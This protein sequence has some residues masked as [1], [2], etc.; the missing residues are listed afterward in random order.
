MP[1]N[2]YEIRNE[3]SLADPE[4][5]RAADKDDPEALLEGVAMAGLVGV[6]RQLG[7]LA[8][9]AAEIFRDL[10]EEVMVTAARGH[11]LMV[12]VEQLE[13]D[14]PLIEKAFLSQTNHSSFF[15]N[16]GVDWH[17]N[18]KMDQNL[19]TQG[20]LP[21]FIMDSYEECRGPP[22][23]FLLDKFDVAGAGAC[24]KRYTDPSSFK[25]EALSSG[26]TSTDVQRVKKTR[27]AKQKKGPHWRNGE[28]REVV[29]PTAHAK[30]HQ[31]FLKE[32]V[33]NGISNPARR[34]KLKRKLNGFPFNLKTGKS[35]MEKLLN[36]SSPEHKVVHEVS[37]RSSPLKLPTNEPIETGPKVLEVRPV[38]T[39]TKSVGRGR[40][41]PSSP[42]REGP[43]LQASV[44][45][46]NE[47]STDDR[48]SEVSIPNPIYEADNSSFASHGVTSG[49]DI[50][51]DEESKTEGSLDG[52]QSDD[53]A[54]ERENYVD[55]P[56]TMDSE[57]DTD[58]ELRGKSDLVSLNI[59]RQ[60]SISDANE[61]QLQAHSSGSQSVATSTLS[62]DGK[63]EMSSFSLSDT[64]ST[65][66]EN[67]PSNSD[68]S[69][70]ILSSTN[71]PETDIL[72]RS[73][74]L[75]TGHGDDS[76][77]QD[78]KPV[79]TDDTCVGRAEIPGHT[80]F[81][82][83]IPSSCVTDAIPTSLDLDSTSVVGKGAFSQSD[84]MP[85]TNIEITGE[86]IHTEHDGTNM[87]TNL[88]YIPSIPSAALLV[89]DDFPPRLSAE[90]HLTDESNG[91]MCE[92]VPGV[93]MV[94]DV[95]FHTGDNSLG[96]SAE[97]LNS[98]DSDKEDLNLHENIDDHLYMMSSKNTISW[99]VATDIPNLH[100]N[101]K[102]D[103]S[104]T[105][106][107][108]N[109]V[110]TPIV[111][112]E[113]HLVDELDDE[114]PNVFSDA[115]NDLS[116]ILEAAPENANDESSLD[117]MAQTVGANDDSTCT[118]VYNPIGSPNLI[119]PHTEENSLY[120]PRKDFGPHDACDFVISA[121]TTGNEIP[122]AE[123]PKSC[124]SLGLQGMGISNDA[125]PLVLANVESSHCSEENLDEPLTTSNG[126]EVDGINLCT[127]LIEKDATD[128]TLSSDP[129]S[130]DEVH[131]QLDEINSEADQSG[132]VV[133][134][135][136]V[137]ATDNNSN[138]DG[139]EVWGIN[140]CIE[141]TGKDASDITL[142]PD[143]TSLNKVH[144]QLDEMDSESYQSG[145]VVLATNVAA[146]DINSDED[147]VSSSVDLNKLPE[148]STCSSGDLDQN[149]FK[150]ETKYLPDS[151]KQSGLA[152]EVDQLEATMSGSDA[153][154]C[155]SPV[156]L[157]HPKSE[158]SVNVPHSYRDLEVENTSDLINAARTQS[159]LEQYGLA[160]E[161]ESR[162]QGV[163]INHVEDSSTSHIHHDA[164]EKIKLLPNQSYQEDFPD[165]GEENLEV[166]QL[167]HVQNLD[168]N[169]PEGSCNASC[170]LVNIQNQPFI[171]EIPVPGSYDVNMSGYSKD[172][173]IS[174]VPPFNL[175]SEANLINLE[176]LPPLPPLPPV[177]WRTGKLQHASA[178]ERIAK[179]HNVG[180]FLSSLPVVAE[181]NAQ[182]QNLPL[183]AAKH[184]DSPSSQEYSTGN[185]M[186]SGT[187]SSQ[188][189]HVDHPSNTENNCLV[190]RG[191]QVMNS[192][193]MLP[194]RY[195]EMPQDSFLMEKGCL[196][197]SRLT[198]F[199]QETSVDTSSTN[200]VNSSNE[201]IRPSYHVAPE[202]SSKEEEAPEISS[203]EEVAP[204]INSKVK[205]APEIITK[206]EKLV[207]S[208]SSVEVHHTRPKAVE[209]LPP[210]MPVLVMP[211]SEGENTSPP[212]EDGIANGS[213]SMKQPRPR[214]PLIDAV[215]ARDKS[216]LR[217]VTERIRPEIQKVDERD[218][219]LEQIRS[220]SFNLKPAVAN[221]PS[222]RGPKTNLKVAA[223]LEK[224][225][226]I[227]QAF[228]GS[229]D[230]DEDR[231][232]DP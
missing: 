48:I 209:F 76:V 21:R 137:A 98:N 110:C 31:L 89:K 86:L 87:V 173:L 177:Q 54:S 161:Q 44:Y 14:V 100:E 64:P 211:S 93:S 228:V 210:K 195:D 99:I 123:N 25:V 232:S 213:R 40:S 125:Y 227:R 6:L 168:H 142:S 107:Q 53:I 90:N 70:E 65:S 220:K 183:S 97:H 117:N 190:L 166:P 191:N 186:Q 4:L 124:D 42:D 216:K 106:S 129:T 122:V 141:F 38:S 51:V 147:D 205:V 95:H 108:Y 68:V 69:V 170:L 17:P 199:S 158:L 155:S 197:Q 206:E 83:L 136:T 180:Q 78:P 154:L 169:D 121:E 9:F 34:V 164:E 109:D 41:P 36:T 198:A 20:D 149:E 88:S 207:S 62:D 138:E 60:L 172:P 23:L 188:V 128:I 187:I 16:S 58:S 22:R 11:G 146:T 225:N 133:I 201:V 71:I 212:V 1:M 43:I 92:N 231:W 184:E 10:H 66:A 208:S 94:S 28:T 194:E 181:Q 131:V 46:M 196:V 118:L 167:K 81:G 3:Y 119:L 134:A 104:D 221:R 75:E 214:N 165:T 84:I 144:V 33:E 148:A 222:I 120:L 101:G 39:D 74:H 200:N 24:L 35:Y 113:K 193:T 85:S 67:S 19:I 82:D 12:R 203:K 162:W 175:L 77:S 152:K 15:Y 230:D 114:N 102:S 135:T 91:S 156:D 72:D 178:P 26:M 7:D 226:A 174:T 189:P 105:I 5:Y 163:H 202:I 49:K 115:S 29:L 153:V 127:D 45:E 139:V 151:C 171:S 182:N 80:D 179:Q 116:C 224:A 18:Q 157:D 63:K 55:A 217:K 37:V 192:S 126:L 111:S 52:Y 143:P 50:S 30:L 56:S 32:H 223:I 218:S 103:H 73:S 140:P 229:D 96:T 145:T 160:M 132:A 79:V 150:T 176:E 215:V 47:I 57:M 185:M 61:Q 112:E 2:R 59:K 159:A 204:E 27:K 13:T 130:L 8:E 219:L